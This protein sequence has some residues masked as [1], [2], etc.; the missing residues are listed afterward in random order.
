MK[1]G[2]STMAIEPQTFLNVTKK[3]H[4]YNIWE[5]RDDGET[6]LDE[7]RVKEL[8]SIIKSLNIEVNIHT[9]FT[10]VNLCSNSAG[11]RE[12]SLEKIKKSIEYAG[13]L[14]SKYVVIHSCKVAKF[15]PFKYNIKKELRTL[16]L[17][18]L[19][20]IGDYAY[21]NGVIPLL[22]NPSNKNYV[23]YNSGDLI[24][25]LKECKYYKLLID[26]GHA[27][28]TEQFPSIFNIPARKIYA[29]H[30]NNNDGVKDRH[31]ALDRGVIDWSSLLD[32]LTNLNIK[33]LIIEVIGWNEAYRSLNIVKSFFK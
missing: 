28:I 9:P 8:L 19:M 30:L 15:F 12:V 25:V 13:L 33:Y 2:L 11:V 6:F 32:K 16:C 5:Y 3:L 23:F 1:L 10:N 22:E 21:E 26:V 24:K 14:E 20:E 7:Y 31:W 17:N 29:V 27:V 4:L 18:A